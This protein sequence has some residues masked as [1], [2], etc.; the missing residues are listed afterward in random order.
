[1]ARLQRLER[2]KRRSQPDDSCPDFVIAPEVAR[3]IVDDYDCLTRLLSPLWAFMN[4]MLKKYGGTP[5]PEPDPAA[6]EEAAARLAGHLRE[7]HC[8]PDYWAKQADTDRKKLRDFSNS[9]EPSASGDEGVQLRARLIVF[10]GSPD[11]AAWR[12][13]MELSYRKRTCAQQAELDELHRR[14]PGM[15]LKDY[16]PMYETI[17]HMEE[18]TRK[19]RAEKSSEQ[20]AFTGHGFDDALWKR[21]QRYR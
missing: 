16:N 4:R 7:I 2:L 14:Y 13:M 19:D 11:G 6:E 9:V 15:P 8:P 10:D 5:G 18:V 20:E 12:R 1:L 3:A 21:V 17:R